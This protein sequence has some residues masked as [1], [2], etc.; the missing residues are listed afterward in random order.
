MRSHSCANGAH[1]WGTH[2]LGMKAMG[3]V[4]SDGLLGSQG[5]H[6]VHLCGSGSGYC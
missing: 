3:R 6:G 4:E 5:F 1:E 2:M